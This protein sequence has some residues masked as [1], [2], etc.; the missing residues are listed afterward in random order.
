MP[1]K[2]NS[3]YWFVHAL[4]S[5]HKGANRKCMVNQ[6]WWSVWRRNKS[7]LLLSRE[8]CQRLIRIIH[9]KVLFLNHFE[10]QPSNLSKWNLLEKDKTTEFWESL[11]EKLFIVKNLA[12]QL[13]KFK[14]FFIS[15]YVYK[16]PR[17]KTLKR[18]K[19]LAIN[20]R[21]TRMK[22]YSESTLSPTRQKEKA[23]STQLHVLQLI[24]NNARL[25][26]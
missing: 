19:C 25:W 6:R 21:L 2:C 7:W 20:S 23:L 10:N 26:K 12:V 14:D 13:Q 15:S 8:H 11:L 18:R 17:N 22:T 4:L 5:Y 16:I 1:S 3:W 24:S 9:I